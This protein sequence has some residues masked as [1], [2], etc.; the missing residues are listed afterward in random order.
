MIPFYTSKHFKMNKLKKIISLFLILN[1]FNNNTYS[2]VDVTGSTGAN[3]TYSTLG[4]AFTA[5]GTAQTGNNI[6]ITITGNT[7]E[8]AIA[9]LGAGTWT[10]LTINRVGGPWTIS[11]TMATEMIL[12]SG[13]D[14]VTVNGNDSLIFANLSTASTSGTST[15]KF[16]NEATNNTFN[17][18]S[19]LGSA[20]MPVGTNGGN[21]FISTSIAGGVGNDNLSFNSCKFGPAGS[22]TPTKTFYANGSTTN[23]NIANS[24]ITINNCEF[25]DFYQG[26]AASSAGIYAST[27]NT[28]WNI[29]NNKFYQTATRTY[30]VSHSCYGIY[31]VNTTFGDSLIIMGNT[32][33]GSNN[34]GSGLMSSST[35]TL[36]GTFTAINF[37]LLPTATTVSK[38]SNNTIK[39]IF[40][41]STSGAPTFLGINNAQT[42]TTS[43]NTIKIENNILRNLTSESSGQFTGILCGG[44]GS[45]LVN[46]NIIDTIYRATGTTSTSGA[47]SNLIHFSG[48]INTTISNN[49]IQNFFFTSTTVNGATYGITDNSGTGTTTTS[50]NITDNTITNFNIAANGAL[51]LNGIYFLSNTNPPTRNILNNKISKFNYS[52]STTGIVYGLRSNGGTTVN[53]SN[54]VI[55]SF[56]GGLGTAV[57][58]W[59]QAATTSFVNENKISNLSSSSVSGLVTG[60]QVSTVA[61]QYVYNNIISDI[62]TPNDTSNNAIKAISILGGTTIHVN[63]NTINLGNISPMTSTGAN[64]GGSGIF[65]NNATVNVL[66]KNNIIKIVGT[67]NGTGY[68]APLKM[69]AGITKTNLI[70]TNNIY[71]NNGAYI[72]GEGPEIALATNVYYKDVS[73]YTGTA[74]SLFNTSCGLYK[75]WMGETGTYWENNLVAGTSYGTFKPSGS[76]YAE[77]GATTSTANLVQIDYLGVVRS[78]TPDIGAIEFAGSP[79]NTGAPVISYTPITNTICTTNPTISVSIVDTNGGVSVAS[80]FKPRLYFKKT[81]ETN[82]LPATNTSASNGW[83]WVEATNT[84]SPFL[85]TIDYS[86]LNSA[87]AAGNTIEYFIIAQDSVSTPNVS[88][89]LVTFNTGFCPTSVNLGAGAFP[90][91][92]TNNYTINTIPATIATNATTTS[93]CQTGSTTLSLAGTPYAGA[94]YQWE[95]STNGG[96][97]YS[98]ISGA[99]LDSLKNQTVSTSTLFRA[100]ILCGT[101]AIA[102]SPT[103]PVTV[104]VSQTPVITVEPVSQTT[105]CEGNAFTLTTTSTN[106]TSKQ[107]YKNGVL[108]TGKTDSFI[109]VSAATI[110]D[111][112]NYT[113]IAL[114]TSPCANDTTV[115]AHVTVNIGI[116]ISKQPNS[117][118]AI[119]V[120]QGQPFSLVTHAAGDSS[121]V[122]KKIVNNTTSN[123]TFV[124]DSNYFSSAN[125]TDSG[126]YFVEFK[127]YAPCQIKNS[128]TVTVTVNPLATI[129]TDPVGAK[130]CAGS[131]ITLSTVSTNAANHVWLKNGSPLTIGGN[132]SVANTSTGSTLTITNSVVTDSGDYKVI[133]VSAGTCLN[134]T[135]NVTAVVKVIKNITISTQPTNVNVCQ[136]TPFTLT[137]VATGDSSRFWTKIGGSISNTTNTYSVASTQLSDSGKYFLTYK[138]FHPCSDK[139]TDTVT[140]A[141][142][143]NAFVITDPVTTSTICEGQSVTLKGVYSNSLG[144]QWLKNGV[145]ISGATLDSLVVTA[146]TTADSG[147]YQVIVTSPSGCINDT[148]SAGTGIVKVKKAVSITSQ[149]IYTKVCENGLVNM[150]V[151]ALNA[152]AYQWKLNGTNISS[153]NASTY[154]IS[155][156]LAS[157]GGVY[158]VNISGNSPCPIILSDTATL[159]VVLNAKIN[160]Q[161][162]DTI[163]CQN[164]NVAFNINASN[165]IGYQWQFN[166][167][168]ISSATNDSFL[169]S[170]VQSVDSGMY[171]VIAVSANNCKNDTS[172]SVLGKII[173]APMVLVQP[174]AVSNACVGAQFNLPVT[175]SNASSVVWQKN[176]TNTTYTSSNLSIPNFSLSDT[177]I[178][179]LVING[180][181]PCPSI[182]SD[183]STIGYISAA[184]ISTD[185]PS[186]KDHCVGDNMVLKVVSNNTMSYIWKKNGAVVSG[187]N[188]DSLVVNN[189]SLADSGVYQVIAVAQSGCINDTSINMTLKI[190][191]PIVISTQPVSSQTLCE[192]NT[193]NLNVATTFTTGITYQWYQNTVAVG[194]NSA[195]FSKSN[196]TTLDSGNYKVVM[197][198]HP[199]CPTVTSNI[200]RVDVNL[201]P[202]FLSQPNSVSPICEGTSF[203]IVS[204]VTNYSSLLWYKN[205]VALTD[206]SKILTRNSAMTSDLGLYSVKVMAL[207]GC[208]DSMSYSYSLDVKAKVSITTQPQGAVLVQ[209]PSTPPYTMSVKASGNRPF[210]YVWKKNGIVIPT[211]TDSFY[212]ITSFVAA[213]DTGV[214]TVEVS[215]GSPCNNTVVSS[216]A[217]IKNISCPVINVQPLSTTRICI[218]GNTSLEVTAIGAK[219]YQWYFNGT[220]LAG[221]TTNKITF[222][223]AV[224][225][226]QGTYKVEVKPYSTATCAQLFSND[227][228]LYVIENPVITSQPAKKVYCNPSSHTMT[229]SDVGGTK[230]QWFKNNVA[231]A[232]ATNKT[233][234]HVG[235]TTF[236][237]EFYVLVGNNYC[238]GTKSN[239]VFVKAV[240]PSEKIYLATRNMYDLK[241]Q[242]MDHNGFTYYSERDNSDSFYIAINK[243]G[244]T[245]TAS[246][247]IEMQSEIV[248]RS[249]LNIENRGVLFGKRLFNI[250]F[251]GTLTQPY[252]V[253]FYYSAE[254]ES[255]LRR[256]YDTIKKIEKNRFLKA[257]GDS[258]SYIVTNFQPMNLNLLN[259]VSVPINFSNMIV[260]DYSSG[261]DNN[262]KYVVINNLV[263][264]N[265]GG[266]MFMDYYLKNTHLVITNNSEEIG[267]KL[268]PVPAVNELNVEISTPSLNPLTLVVYDALGRAL[269]ERKVTISTHNTT[270]KLDVSELSTGFYTLEVNSIDSKSIVKFSK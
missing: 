62:T 18:C 146:T 100:N 201:R 109:T 223:N 249:S 105:L 103:T 171:R 10:S 165:A 79:I 87:I 53:Y 48:G 237:D 23:A 186:T 54:N 156:A 49:I 253:K 123:T 178:Y 179:K 217:I 15:I 149:P 234:T 221:Q 117:L 2:Q 76:S 124:I 181:T 139:N 97:S 241:E 78:T 247:D 60:I 104:I 198:A 24:N 12:F 211:A 7:T 5:I 58:I 83:K 200:A 264:K 170:N 225:A 59:S 212:T 92:A 42:S 132:I 52:N 267:L 8:T 184:M 209:D 141:V 214:Y 9:T 248:E 233:Y 182:I 166:Q 122:W 72:Y 265:G 215:T 50:V 259:N 133:A 238:V 226:Q 74:D 256:R 230:Y 22:N 194:T 269:L 210:T 250:D 40:R 63:Y 157:N 204:D 255:S 260:S 246:P 51:A 47:P 239:T 84:V 61:T 148:S 244:N 207:Q 91:T 136:N 68:F 191:K 31:F 111:T 228:F 153:A 3:A 175:V 193:L 115:K 202:N 81:T 236:G 85:F 197:T 88:A 27:G 57:G 268:Y 89:N 114:G 26:G 45:L 220:P 125:I 102:S 119:N 161:P 36:G 242:C 21:V 101:T 134:D 33:G 95:S 196:I 13:A 169:K 113:M 120:C 64:F 155:S 127:G 150:S 263:A 213:S 218:Q 243:N 151:T 162:R 154:N 29:T 38:I 34:T 11:G 129:S 41:T 235:I 4:A 164:L 187:Q 80:G 158:T 71:F 16:N 28:Q 270:F 177:G 185:L 261:Y 96:T 98:N 189:V 73:G 65:I 106:A 199:S 128:D 183:S 216:N 227:A 66:S 108:L 224:L 37:S 75:S 195:S 251:N 90:V 190:H 118:G 44:A 163:V 144:Y 130:V 173:P 67:P 266:T 131:T 107:W 55:D 258:L 126:K 140:V 69:G 254:D 116:V 77:S 219:G 159:N 94:S 262:I 231:I 35:S 208:N 206:T 46:G 20:T 135:S 32:I 137:A 25:F 172:I 222:T 14:N 56:S 19:I 160:M 252:H 82:T 17:N 188:T 176:G 110:S 245:A 70:A 192:K 147:M 168:N 180:N 93:I 240:E 145:A 30:T 257:R 203:S 99:T 229:V 112:G 205:G 143:P 43:T 232:G 142:R 1:L 138:G 121:L 174:S 167:S 39:N 152:T 86:L 6:V